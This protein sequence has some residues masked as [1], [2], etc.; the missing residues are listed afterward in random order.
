MR[1]TVLRASVVA[2]VLVLA[3]TG[4]ALAV[5]LQAGNLIVIAEGG[6]TPTRLPRGH[7]APIKLHG[8]GRIL[9]SDGSTPPILK[10]IELLFDKH[11]SVV[12]TGLPVCTKAKI[13][14][15]D[16][17]QAR[18]QCPGAIVG[19]GFGKAVV[20]FPEQKPIPA[21][22]PITLFNG[23]P[24]KHGNPTVLAHAYLDVPAPTTYI[25]SVEIQRINDG[26]FGYK[27]V[28]TLPRIA[29][30]AGVPLYGELTI[31]R[32]WT[33][34]GKKLSYINAECPDGRL[35]AEGTFGFE[36]G[37]SLTG[38]FVKKCTVIK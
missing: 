30:G 15:T 12:T 25:I 27:T 21:S 29:G 1:K 23:P 6:P 24:G 19:K 22:S 2:A 3:A 10:T 13:A 37:T 4:T 28:A 38:S 16:T 36:D 35:E 31:G 32:T 20:L 9:T 26:R 17:A 5:R 33:Y 34:K 11:G 8:H 7:L 14:A 18:K